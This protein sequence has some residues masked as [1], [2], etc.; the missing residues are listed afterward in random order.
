MTN[1]AF[2]VSDWHAIG[3]GSLRGTFTAH[4]PSG[5]LIHEFGSKLPPSPPSM[6]P[7]ISR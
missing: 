3:R 1:A 7:G 4:L 2:T 6:P 5:L